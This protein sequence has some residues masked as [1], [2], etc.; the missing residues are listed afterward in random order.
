M[1]DSNEIIH[2]SAKT[3]QQVS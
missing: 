3:L 2:F 1:R